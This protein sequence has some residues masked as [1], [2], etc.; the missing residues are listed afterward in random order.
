MAEL[1]AVPGIQSE[2]LQRTRLTDRQTDS[3]VVRRIAQ[4]HL[5]PSYTHSAT[6]GTGD[7]R[8]SPGSARLAGCTGRIGARLV[9]RFLLARFLLAY[10]L[11]PLPLL[12]PP[13]QRSCHRNRN[14]PLS[15]RYRSIDRLSGRSIYRCVLYPSLSRSCSPLTFASSSPS[16]RATRPSSLLRI[17]RPLQC[18]THFFSPEYRPRVIVAKTNL[19][20]HRAQSLYLREYRR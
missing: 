11:P 18:L 16:E 1:V 10:H 6:H 12:P 8:L 19:S 17:E 9:A 15:G 14:K 13:P 20:C 2:T 3:Q 7:G 4:N 5:C